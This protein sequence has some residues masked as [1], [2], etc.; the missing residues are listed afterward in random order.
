MTNKIKIYSGFVLFFAG[1][2]FFTPALAITSLPAGGSSF[3]TATPLATGQ[4]QG[5]ALLAWQEPFYYSVRVG[6]GQQ[7]TAEARSFAQSGCTVYLYGDNQEELTYS[8]DTNP[9]IIWLANA[10]KSVHTYYL[11]IVNDASDVSSFTLS[12][13]LANYYDAG[14][15]T[16]AG[17]TFDQ[18]LTIAPGTYT[19]YLTG[20]A[21]IT[22]DVGDDWQDVYKIGLQKGVT[23]EFKVTPPSKTTLDL[24]LYDANRQ[25]LKEESSANEGAIVTLSLIPAANTNIFLSVISSGYPYQDALVNY[26]L[27]ANSSV[28][29]IQF[30]AC[31]NQECEVVGEFSSQSICHQSST[32]TL[33]SA[34]CFFIFSTLMSGRSIL[35]IA[36]TKGILAFKI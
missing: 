9:K 6:A 35:L 31:N 12:V 30:Y 24:K 23:Y 32:K 5:G 36:I 25:L 28:P 8:Y 21:G 1:V 13:A 18:A 10:D 15:S 27:E 3:G 11:K 4:Y 2:L 20:Y 17:A 33:L 19:S 22:D 29:L 34:N 7:I 26:K 14:S 16:D